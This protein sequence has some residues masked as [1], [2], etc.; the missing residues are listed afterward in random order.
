VG[1]IA[2]ALKTVQLHGESVTAAYV[3]DLRVHPGC[4]GQGVAK[5][6]T[7]VLLKEIGSRAEC[8]Y[9]FI[10]GENEKAL[11]LACRNFRAEAVI[12]LS[13]AVI[14]VYRRLAEAELSEYRKPLQIHQ[15][16]LEANPGT[17]FRAPFEDW[18]LNGHVVSL[19]LNREKSAGCS[20]WSNENVLAEEV[21]RIP[22][23]FRL[24]SSLSAPLRLFLNLPSIPR[25]GEV[26]RSWFLFD[27]YAENKKSLSGL[28]AAVGNFALAN[29]RTYL[30]LLLQKDDPQL[31]WIRQVCR[32]T[33][34]FPYYFLAKGRSIPK[35]SD[36]LY[37]DVRDL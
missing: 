14:P 6:L 8:L 27:L 7:N 20:V 26:I 25:P 23:S 24:M 11:G 16:Y 5:R 4:R 10:H 22:A 1:I 2:G 28:F 9:T 30:Y 37:I 36:H 18:K 21:V 32:R 34:T 35:L 3:Y 29:G 33:F 31:D 13:Y 15:A 19:A 12:P 17:E